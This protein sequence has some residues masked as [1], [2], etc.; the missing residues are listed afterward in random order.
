MS[1]VFDRD[2]F[3]DVE[4]AHIAKFIDR[5]IGN[6]Q[7][8]E[9]SRWMLARQIG[10]ILAHST[11]YWPTVVIIC[12]GCAK[13]EHLSASHVLESLDENSADGEQT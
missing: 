2:N 4:I 1:A 8:K 7:C 12:S 5:H 6:C 10:K 9:D 13:M 3:S 11:R